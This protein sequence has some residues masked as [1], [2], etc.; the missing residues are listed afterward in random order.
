MLN[1]TNDQA[2]EPPDQPALDP[3][4]EALV[5]AVADLAFELH[6]GADP[7]MDKQF[8]ATALGSAAVTDAPNPSP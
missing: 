3:R 5:R 7:I 2:H 8:G 4:L 1:E 6:T